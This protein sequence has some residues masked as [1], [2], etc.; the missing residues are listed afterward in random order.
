MTTSWT[1][2][3]AALS[4]NEERGLTW[5]NLYVQA[6]VIYDTIIVS[7]S[8]SFGYSSKRVPSW[9]LRGNRP[10]CHSHLN[11]SSL[12]QVINNKQQRTILKFIYKILYSPAPPDAI[13]VRL[14]VY[15]VQ[16]PMDASLVEMFVEPGNIVV[17]ENY[18][19]IPEDGSAPVRIVF[20]CLYRSNLSY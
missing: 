2:L 7:I 10:W 6:D 8:G 16:D 9:L 4:L 12:R 3:S 1:K 13:R 18:V 19:P 15:Q 14:R 11:C 17:H 20:N 5:Y